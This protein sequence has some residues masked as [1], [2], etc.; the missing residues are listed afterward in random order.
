MKYQKQAGA[1][2]LAIFLATEPAAAQTPE[3][4]YNGKQINFIIGYPAGSGYDIYARLLATHMGRHIPG[5]PTLVPQNMP[6]AGSLGATNYIYARAPRDG[7]VIGAINRSVPLAPL[8]QAVAADSVNFDPLKFTWLGSMSKEFTIGFVWTA[9]G[10]SGFDDLRK[11][12][13]TTGTAA[14]TADGFVFPNMMNRMLGTKLKIILGYPGTK[15]V[16][17]AVER[18]ELDGYFGGSLSSLLGSYPGWISDGKIKI[19]VQI[20][21]EKAPQLPDVP[22]LSEFVRTDAE[23]QA[24]KLVLS[25]QLMGRPYLA[26]PEVPQDRADALRAAFAQTMKDPAFLADAGKLGVDVSPMRGDEILAL[27]KDLYATPPDVVALA[28]EA[29]KPPADERPQ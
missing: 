23:R 10:I 5:Q 7:T 2:L 15:E 22:L 26:P 16:Y 21:L 28:R 20:A 4:F 3:Q 6:A 1:A 24:L 17:L 11:R 27:L 18:G 29:L 25:P 19:L 9:S 14:V 12:Q 13:V 8:L